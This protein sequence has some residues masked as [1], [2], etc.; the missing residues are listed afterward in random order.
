MNEIL[1]QRIE[2]A[3]HEFDKEGLR[4]IFENGANF[5]LN[6]LWI[7][8]EEALPEE[9]RIIAKISTDFCGKDD[10][11]EILHRIAKE[12]IDLRHPDGYYDCCGE[13][14][15]TSAI[16]HWMAIPPIEGGEK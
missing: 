1:Q 5:I 2:E 7:S 16:T 12:H 4:V 10:C 11:Y 9:K 3:A 8:V 6:N 14:V 13:S 15:P